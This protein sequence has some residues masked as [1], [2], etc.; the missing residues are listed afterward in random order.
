MVN[1]PGGSDPENLGVD[2]RDGIKN[3]FLSG[4]YVVGG[5][6]YTYSAPGPVK[7]SLSLIR[8]EWPI[9]APTNKSV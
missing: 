3:E 4:N 5:V 7:M 9:P 6:K 2:Q 8:R 1:R